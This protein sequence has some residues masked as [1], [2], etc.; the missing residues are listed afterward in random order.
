ME[1]FLLIQQRREINPLVFIRRLRVIPF[2]S[3]GGLESGS[4]N[5]GLSQ[6]AWFW[7][8]IIGAG[9]SL[10]E[11]FRIGWCRPIVGGVVSNQ[12][13]SA[14]RWLLGSDKLFS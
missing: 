13:I 6:S 8:E 9:P 7:F 12:S 5:S 14:R 3:A 1:I 4:I 11:L 10:V 2:C